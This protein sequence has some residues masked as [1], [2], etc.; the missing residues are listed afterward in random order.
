MSLNPLY[1]VAPNIQYYFVD[2]DTGEPLSQGKV[3]F[4][5]DVDMVT[6]K[7]V[8][9][10]Q[11]NAANYTYSALPNPIILSSVGTI[12]DDNGNQVVP[13]YKPTD[14]NGNQDLYYIVVQNA[15]GAPQFT[16]HAWPNP[17]GGNIPPSPGDNAI[18]NYIPNGQ[19]L[20]HTD[21]PNN[22][23]LPGSNIIAQGGFSIELDAGATSVNTLTWLFQQPTSEPTA[24]PRWIAD[25]ICTVPVA[26]EVNKSFRIKFPDVNKFND[27]GTFT[28]AFWAIATNV[29]PITIAVVK[30]FGSGNSSGLLAPIPVDVGTITTSN[31]PNGLYNFNIS[32]GSNAGYTVG[33]NDDDWIAIDIIF[34]T[35]DTFNVE[36]ADFT[37]IYGANS[38]ISAFPIQ[39]NASML[40]N[41][42][43]GWVPTPNPDGSDLYLA[44][45]LTRQGMVWDHSVIGKIEA[46]SGTPLSPNNPLNL[47]NDMPCDGASY[48][49][50]GFSAIGIPYSR[51][52]DFLITGSIAGYPVYGTGLDYGTAWVDNAVNTSTYLMANAPGTPIAIASD[53]GGGSGFTFG[54]AITYAGAQTGTTALFPIAQWSG[55]NY[56]E[57]LMPTITTDAIATQG[58][59]GSTYTIFSVATS[60]V[61]YQNL[62]G[63]SGTT[64]A[65]STM[66]LTG[67][68]CPY[69]AF[70]LSSGAKYLLY[71]R[72][73]STGSTPDIAGYTKWILDLPITTTAI[74]VAQLTSYVLQGL[75]VSYLGAPVSAPGVGTF[76]KFQTNPAS[77]RTIVP[78]FSYSS[79]D[80]APVTSGELIRVSL[81]ASPTQAQ[82]ISALN[83]AINAFQFAAPDLRGM[84]LRGVDP[85]STWDIDRLSRINQGL[86]YGG[87]VGSYELQNFLSHTHGA[88]STLTLALG[89]NP[90][91]SAVRLNGS[92][93]TNP[94]TLTVTPVT[95][96]SNSGGSETRPINSY[97]NWI[98]K[99]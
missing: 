85:N 12:V 66:T 33:P 18:Q 64:Q 91:A 48:L 38:F 49:A 88:T 93:N 78:W 20:T 68:N 53:S 63:F 13:Y 79:S 71:Y 27:L 57:A 82:V 95:T 92:A 51:L 26:S 77:L 97:V 22:V 61:S 7:A 94:S 15:V 76:F 45:V 50:S 90:A 19:F 67:G 80:A 84:F 14:E 11:G 36:M 4:Y 74:Q 47:W 56:F 65:A 42:L 58:L 37:L 21:L 6:P 60:L 34:S 59:A 73:A 52:R 16:V 3:F 62:F 17:Q 39:T 86:G 46:S 81:P 30:Y 10:L 40:A 8:Y 5:R 29:T 98:I 87:Y 32:F 31:P 9:E 23:L 89:N 99:Y 25:F 35:A 24:S 2:R 72:V 83:N 75:Q 1:V 55:G 28:F 54:G 69:V 43:A 41:S 96:I 44:P 70:N